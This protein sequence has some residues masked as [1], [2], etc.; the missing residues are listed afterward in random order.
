M[1]TPRALPAP[2]YH[3]NDINGG[4]SGSM[5]TPTALPAPGAQPTELPIG[6]GAAKRPAILPR[7]DPAAVKRIDQDFIDL[8]RFQHDSEAV[9]ILLEYIWAQIKEA[10]A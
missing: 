1:T 2:A 9:L 7:L 10:L 3:A 4:H 8:R 5:T 6:P